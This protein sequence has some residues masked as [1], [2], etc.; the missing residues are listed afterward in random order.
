MLTVLLS[1]G[2]PA[3]AATAQSN[4]DTPTLTLVGEAEQ[5]VTP[6]LAY[7]MIGVRTE[8]DTAGAALRANNDATR[9]VVNLLKNE[10]VDARDIQ[11]RSLSLQPRYPRTPRAGDDRPP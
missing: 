7:L 4:L 9:T 10:G 1:L 11:T 3:M 6:D 2:L 5:A 8:A